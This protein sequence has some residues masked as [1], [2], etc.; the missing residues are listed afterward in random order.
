MRIARGTRGRVNDNPKPE[1]RSFFDEGDVARLDSTSPDAGHH[2]SADAT[3]EGDESAFAWAAIFIE[4]DPSLEL[5]LSEVVDVLLDLDLPAALSPLRWGERDW[6]SVRVR[7]SDR[8]EVLGIQ[9]DPVL[10]WIPILPARLCTAV[11]DAGFTCIV[12]GG[13]ARDRVGGVIPDHPAARVGSIESI[14]FWCTEPRAGLAISA[15][16]AEQSLWTMPAADTDSHAGWIVQSEDD[17][18]AAFLSGAWAS[19][20][21]TLWRAGNRRGMATVHK[22]TPEFFEWSVDWDV[23]DPSQPWKKDEHGAPVRDYLDAMIEP[24][25]DTSV[26][27]DMGRWR[28]RFSL[29]ADRAAELRALSRGTS[30]A[31]T[32]RRVAEIL[33]LPAELADAAEGRIRVSD[34]PGAA[35]IAPAS[36]WAAMRT[37]FED[38]WRTAPLTRWEL[39]WLRHP[40]FWVVVM[41]LSLLA[42]IVFF[43]RRMIAGQPELTWIAAVGFGLWLIEIFAR[44]WA[45][46]RDRAQQADAAAE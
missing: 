1:V 21:I 3:I 23:I 37:M 31:H 42:I 44:R 8:F 26:A 9:S 4:L 27:E 36:N 34:L 15:R 16:V 25:T 20:R 33:G 24:P 7:M 22:K 40:K 2:I 12:V 45:Q 28:E 35:L 38:E 13:E 14:A 18:D 39:F 46:R 11:I 32:F 17:G 10:A 29:D 6:A 43:V 5:G 19:S 30:D 41:S